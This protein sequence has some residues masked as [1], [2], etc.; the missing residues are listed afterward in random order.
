MYQQIGE[1]VKVLGSFEGGSLTPRILK[2]KGRNYTITK[3]NLAYQEREG[4]S[5]NYFYSAETG[6]G[7]VMK[8]RYNNEK[9]IWTLDEIWVE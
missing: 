9:L 5:M 7:M 1:K 2:W 8:L 3:V 4:K 6:G